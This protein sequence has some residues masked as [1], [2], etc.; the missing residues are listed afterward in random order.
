[1]VTGVEDVCGAQIDLIVHAWLSFNFKALKLTFSPENGAGVGAGESVPAEM[2][3]LTWL[4][5]P[6][7]P[8][9]KHSSEPWS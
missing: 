8:N 1:M 6:T 9:R 5:F 2:Q 7:D 3:P 4:T